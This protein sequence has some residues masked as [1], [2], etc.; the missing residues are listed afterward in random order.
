[1]GTTLEL[2][3]AVDVAD[4]Q[5]VRLVQGAAGTETSYGSPREAALAWQRD[6]AEWIHL[7]DLD[8]AFG[9]GNNRELLA[10]VVA[11]LDV[12]VELSGGIRD[13]DSLAA[14]MATG[15]TRVNLGTAA[16]ENPDWCRTAIA[17]YGD[18]IAVGLDVVA[19][20]DSWRL[21]G[22][23]WVT[24]G[25]DLW[26]VL[27]RLNADGCARYVVTDVSK[28]GT[29]KG[30]NLALLAEVAAKTSA[31]IVASGGVSAVEDLVAIAGLVPQGVEGAIV[32]KALYAGRFTLP[33]ALG[34][35]ARA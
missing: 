25:G 23:G 7:V 33:E 28:D 21:R 26:E 30:P 35:V 17:E 32:G 1:M 16:L 24:D 8:A 5:A 29:L 9:K 34:A 22:R 13:D 2:L 15:C 3:P 20:G 10:G 19:E 14:A 6:G 27:D 12:K 11:E 31:P 4:G 18:R